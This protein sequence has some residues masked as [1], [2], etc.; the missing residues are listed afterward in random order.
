MPGYL[1]GMRCTRLLLPALTLVGL[2]LPLGS[3][4]GPA[5]PLLATFTFGLSLSPG[6][7][8]ELFT[9]F[10]VKEFE[11]KV[12][13]TVPLTRNTFMLQAQGAAPSKANPTGENL[14]AKFDIPLCLPLK[15]PEDQRP[16]G[17]CEVFDSLWKL[18]YWDFPYRP[19][20]GQH[21]GKGWSE[22][23]DAPS[24]RQLLLLTDY[25]I[26]YL[27]GM[28]KGENVFRLLHDVS[29]SSWVDNYRKGY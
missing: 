4:A 6:L 26:L 9:L 5:R 11:G 19:M 28:A 20:E 7:N 22:K 15:W 17:D 2:L 21:P 25:G 29:D 10:E 13:G 27:N 1:W 8:N 14:F 24:P 23:R 16:L 18:R 12:I 3:G